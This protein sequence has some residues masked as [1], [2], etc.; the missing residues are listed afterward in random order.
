MGLRLMDG[1]G[2]ETK[3][4]QTKAETRLHFLASIQNVCV[5]VPQE[6]QARRSSIG[7]E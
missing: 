5:R 1:C 3:K 7:G 2:F 6:K 4:H